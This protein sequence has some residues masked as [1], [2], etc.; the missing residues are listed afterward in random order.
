MVPGY[1]FPL[2]ENKQVAQLLINLN[3]LCLLDKVTVKEDK[4]YVISE[5]GK[6]AV[7]ALRTACSLPEIPLTIS[8][9]TQT[10]HEAENKLWDEELCA[11]K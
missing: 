9:L 10:L 4:A 11:I 1:H 8:A 6:N 2:F 7:H 3:A 5:D